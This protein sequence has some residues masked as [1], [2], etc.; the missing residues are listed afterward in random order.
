MKK[1]LTLAVA[2]IAMVFGTAQAENW[3]AGGSVGFMHEGSSNSG[4][5][6][7]NQFSIL[8][9]VGYNINSHWAV[10][11]QVGYQYTHDCTD[12]TSNNMFKINP[13]ARYTFYRSSNNLVQ[14]FVD[15]TVGV[16]LGWTDYQHGSSSTAVTYQVGLKPGIALNVT[17]KFSIV[18]H[19]GLAGYQGVNNAAKAGGNR[20][21]GGFSFDTDVANVGFYYNF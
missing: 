19:L 9:E 11:G 10:G 4:D 17:K 15:G 8:P 13:Y 7:T 14:L 20:A 3:Y 2:A 5:H 21:R 12:V 6:M 18:A 1:I 16:G